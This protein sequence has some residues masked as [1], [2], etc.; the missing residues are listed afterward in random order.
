MA[1]I[2]WLSSVYEAMIYVLTME[3]YK[4]HANRLHPSCCSAGHCSSIVVIQSHCTMEKQLGLVTKADCLLL[5]AV[6][7]SPRESAGKHEQS[8]PSMIEP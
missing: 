1:G 6:K 3:M 5:G 7:T 2:L 4:S 8:L